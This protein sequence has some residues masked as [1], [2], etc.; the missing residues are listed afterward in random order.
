MLP[1]F[2]GKERQGTSKCSWVGSQRKWGRLRERGAPRDEWETR[3]VWHSRQRDQHVPEAQGA[4][5]GRGR[6]WGWELGWGRSQRASW[7]SLRMLAF[8][9]VWVARRHPPFSTRK[10]NDRTW[11][12]ERSCWWGSKPGDRAASLET[13]QPVRKLGLWSRWK[14]TGAGAVAEHQEKWLKSTGCLGQNQQERVVQ[15]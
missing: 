13:G 10:W 2:L 15:C 5:W 9:P 6:I 11:I 7:A 12:L 3:W 1:G 14:I 8:S 4:H